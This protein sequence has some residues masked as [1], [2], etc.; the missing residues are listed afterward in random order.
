MGNDEE[1]RREEIKDQENFQALLQEPFH[2]TSQPDSGKTLFDNIYKMIKPGYLCTEPNKFYK[3]YRLKKNIKCEDDLI[4]DVKIIEKKNSGQF[5]K[6][7]MINREEIVKIGEQK[8]LSLFGRELYILDQMKHPNLETLIKI[9][10]F[11]EKGDSFKIILVTNYFSSYSLLDD[12]NDHIAKKKKYETSEVKIVARILITLAMKFK[13]SSIIYKNFS[14][15]NI[16]FLKKGYYNSILLKNFYFS[17]PVDKNF[18]SSGVTGSLWYM[19]P[20]IIRDQ[21]YDF[22]VD[23]WGI[24]LIIYVLLTLENPFVD[25]KKRTDM[26]NRLQNEPF[27]SEEKMKMDGVDEDLV[28]LVTNLLQQNPIDRKNCEKLFE[29]DLFNCKDEKNEIDRDILKK[30]IEYPPFFDEI[31]KVKIGTTEIGKIIH[32]INYYIID[33][34]C[35]L[36]LDIDEK[37]LIN[38]IFNFL[39]DSKDGT[40]NKSEIEDKLREFF[41]PDGSKVEDGEREK[42]SSSIKSYSELVWIILFDNIYVV[43]YHGKREGS[44][45]FDLFLTCN[46]ILKILDNKEGDFIKYITNILFEDIDKDNNNIIDIREFQ[47][48]IQRK[49]KNTKFKDISSVIKSV[50]DNNLKI[51]LNK[52]DRDSFETLLT[53]EIIPLT[54]KQKNKIEEINL[55]KKQEKENKNKKK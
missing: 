4:Y 27:R 34:I 40:L 36:V 48:F 29:D 11:K 33:N 51:N 9:Y 7:K 25:C 31:I 46:I 32:Y 30:F 22:Q 3:Q 23:M 18:S 20:E 38:D 39:D 28:D 10:L 44:I 41:F 42:I 17:S 24:G 47:E 6:A 2:F 21:R 26:L 13:N 19:A 12:I 53:Y 5:L 45:D 35:N 14:P 54:L 37:I 43:E 50:R 15:E 55:N 52:M 1:G 16:F 8:F 49:N